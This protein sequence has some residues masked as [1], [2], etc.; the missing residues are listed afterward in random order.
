MNK[1]R[2]SLVICL[3]LLLVFVLGITSAFAAPTD[4]ILN[5]NITADVNDD[6]TVHLTFHIDWKV[7]ES[8]GIGPLEWVSIGVPNKHI[9]NVIPVSSN[10]SRINYSS[11][12]GSFVEV[13]F[14]KKYYK[15][16][17]ASFDFELDADYL[18]SMNALEDG[19]TVYYYLPGW[20]DGI[21]V[22][23]YEV[24]WNVEKAE[25]WDEGA[26]IRDGYLV[27]SGKDAYGYMPGIKVTYA[28]DAFAFDD[29][30]EMT[31]G[32]EYYGDTHDPLEPLY[33]FIGVIVVFSPLIFVFSVVVYAF[34]TYKKQSGFAT[35]TK[36]TR[37]KI[38]YYANCPSC[39][40][41][42]KD[43]QTTCEYCGRSFV[44]SEEVIKEDTVEDKDA[45]KYSKDGEYRYGSSPNTY[46]RVNVVHVPVSRPSSSSRSSGR[47]GSGRSGGCAHS[48]C[49]CA[50]V[51]CACACACACAGGGRAGCT[52]KD[53]Y[54]TGLKLKSLELRADFKKEK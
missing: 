34:R 8:D 43:G 11:S 27:W 54:N 17:V 9:D 4:E 48:S 16:E 2:L 51:S 49:A 23:N 15:N 50:C 25:S 41:V 26:V 31:G 13:H 42:R 7:L 53:F 47:S 14:D 24:R 35:K 20:F 46:V 30:K 33:M 45:L 21:N 36:I 40:S 38:E 52:A 10:I 29:S 44:K 22:D 1:K 19:F 32:N 37:T 28:N 39:G 12:G 18:Y 3:A 5:Y 6:A